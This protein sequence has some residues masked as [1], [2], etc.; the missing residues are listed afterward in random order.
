MTDVKLSDGREIVF[1]LYK[2]TVRD[3]DHLTDPNQPKA[4]ER[5]TLA[6]VCGLSVD[7]IESLP[8]PDY[9]RITRGFVEACRDP[10]AGAE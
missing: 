5:A 10:L 8:Y 1:D 6:K 2:M 4:E 7:E 9:H 3:W